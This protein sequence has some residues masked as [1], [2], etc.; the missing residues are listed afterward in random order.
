METIEI[1]A[2]GQFANAVKDLDLVS[3]KCTYHYYPPAD[4]YRE[5][6]QVW[7]LSKSDFDNICAIDDDDWKE[8]WGWWRYALGS[9]LGA[10]SYSC[11]INGE[12]IM[13]WHRRRAGREYEDILSYLCIELGVSSEKNVCALTTDLAN[14]NRLTLSE[15]FR[16]YLG[17]ESE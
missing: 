1:L 15:L 11:T 13:V 5:E 6:Y 7:L 4:S 12:K 17:G 16:K 3:A 2:G 9:N 8:S 10:V 14:Q